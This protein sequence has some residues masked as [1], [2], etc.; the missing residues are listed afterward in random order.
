MTPP[1]LSISTNTTTWFAYP[2]D[3]GIHTLRLTFPNGVT[4]SFAVVCSTDPSDSR[5]TGSVDV[6]GSPGTQIAFASGGS[7]NSYYVDIS[8]QKFIGIVSTSMAGG[9]ATAELVRATK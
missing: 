6:P 4:G 2:M 5:K 9:A 3:L 1:V 7:F 8:G